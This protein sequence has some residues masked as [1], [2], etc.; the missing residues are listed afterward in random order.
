[1]DDSTI[2]IVATRA[3]VSR[4]SSSA[5]WA[6]VHQ[7]GTS[8]EAAITFPIPDTGEFAALPCP[9]GGGCRL[10]VQ[11]QFFQGSTE[12][13]VNLLQGALRN[14]IQSQMEC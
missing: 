2:E 7:A 3:M 10:W 12:V 1:M 6:T 9:G 14:W 8:A 4:G 5:M 13:K 11:P